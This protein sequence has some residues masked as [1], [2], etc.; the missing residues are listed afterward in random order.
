MKKGNPL[1]RCS[2][3]VVLA[4]AFSIF[5]V[6]LVREVM[7][8]GYRMTR[9]DKV[10]LVYDELQM[11]ADAVASAGAARVAGARVSDR[12]ARC[13]TPYGIVESTT[14]AFVYSYGPDGVDQRGAV[15]YDL[16][17][18]VN[19][20]GDMVVLVPEKHKQKAKE[21]LSDCLGR[22]DL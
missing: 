16:S 5:C 20:L 19:S 22:D 18:G 17:N 8:F 12:F 14:R 7:N 10:R 13:G 4:I 6:L 15:I 21:H 1:T 3:Y 9:E 2:I 11:L